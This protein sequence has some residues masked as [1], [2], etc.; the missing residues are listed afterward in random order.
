MKRFR[1][2]ISGLLAAFVLGV[3]PGL[4][5][6]SLPAPVLQLRAAVNS[7]Q[8]TYRHVRALL[9]ADPIADIGTPGFAA[10]IAIQMNDL[11]VPLEHEQADLLNSAVIAAAG[12]TATKLALAITQLVYV[13]GLAYAGA[14]T[15]ATWHE[16]E[17]GFDSALNSYNADVVN[18]AARLG[19]TV[20]GL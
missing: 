4:A 19:F 3:E 15:I 11:V 13:C 10:R 7:T 9:N 20:T 6:A 5:G 14:Q 18:L 1:I 8:A 2:V 12:S 16:Y 17:V